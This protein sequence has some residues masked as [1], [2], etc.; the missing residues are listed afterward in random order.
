MTNIIEVSHIKFKYHEEQEYYTLNDI[1]FHVKR[2]E[3]LSIIGHNGSG[4]STSVRL[5][6]GILE[7]ESG[8]IV[9]DGDLLSE[10]YFWAIHL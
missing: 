1:S 9:V 7:A 8:T 6:N 5:L 2:G 4:K 3:W 10:K